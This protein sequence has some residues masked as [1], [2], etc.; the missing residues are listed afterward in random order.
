M[1]ALPRDFRWLTSS[2]G[3]G[4]SGCLSVVSP[5][6][7]LLPIR[8]AFGGRMD[9]G[10]AARDESDG[11]SAWVT[12]VTGPPGV[13]VVAEPYGCQGVRSEVLT[14]ATRGSRSR[15][16]ASI[17]WN[18][19]GMVLATFARAGKVA[20]SIDLSADPDLMQE[21]LPVALTRLASVW[22]ERGE[23]PV[24]IGAAMVE[25]YTGVTLAQDLRTGER[26]A[27]EPV[28]DDLRVYQGGQDVPTALRDHP[29]LVDAIRDASPERRREI[30]RLA[31]QAAVA[32]ADLHGEAAVRE[33][34]ATGGGD[35][36]ST[37][38]PVLNQLAARLARRR[39]EMWREELDAESFGSIEG[40]LVRQQV[41]ALEGVRQLANPDSFSAAVGAAAA[42]INA[43]ALGASA[44]DV[45][46][47]ESSSG[48]RAESGGEEDRRARLAASVL[49]EALQMADLASEF[50]LSRLPLPLSGDARDAAIA[51][52]RAQQR[53]GA[54]DEYSFRSD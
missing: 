14:R 44:R 16:A 5:L 37:V 48:R 25:H 47:V 32:Q 1:N 38:S 18:E 39:D 19:R 21:N 31:A 29:K 8:E 36:P 7:E 10:E 51:E 28:P 24:S 26:W 27:L 35:A 15:K 34:F 41:G 52:D 4:D 50:V 23:E 12:A 54:F 6:T 20:A 42:L 43:T 30:A 49:E 3:L 53:S 13:V 9:D 40:Q 33:V 45:R 17:Y 22:L 11:G 46:F 2:S